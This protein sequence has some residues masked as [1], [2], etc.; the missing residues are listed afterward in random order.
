MNDG[1]THAERIRFGEKL[2]QAFGSRPGER[3]KWVDRAFYVLRGEASR[4]HEGPRP[5]VFEAE[6]IEIR[7]GG[8][9]FRGIRD[10]SYFGE[11]DGLTIVSCS[12][13]GARAALR[14]AIHDLAAASA[15]ETLMLP[16]GAEIEII[17]FPR[18]PR[19]ARRFGGFTALGSVMGVKARIHNGSS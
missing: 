11:R 13:K 19:R 18:R 16:Q 4:E 1:P 17:E 3:E 12:Q 6:S 14:R 9:V 8:R 10:I 2:W 7:V 15:R 5:Q